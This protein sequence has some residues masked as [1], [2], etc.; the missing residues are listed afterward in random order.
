V[1]KGVGTDRGTFFIRPYEEKDERGVLSLWEA[2]FGKSMSP[3]LFK[4]K[5][6]DN[7][8]GHQMMLCV[9]EDGTPVAMYSGIPFRANWQGETVRF[10]HL[11]DHSSHPA[12]RSALG[13][14]RGLFVRT[15]AEFFDRYGGPHGSVFMYG[16]P[17][18][19]HFF[20]GEKLLQYVPLRGGMTFMSARPSDVAFQMRSFKGR[21]E[22]FDSVSGAFDVLSEACRSAYPFSV[23]RDAAFLN[24]RFLK[25]P[26]RRYEIWGYRPFL[27]RTLKAYA[28]LFHEPESSCIVDLFSL[29][30]DVRLADFIARLVNAMA[31]N[32]AQELKTWLPPDHFL[33][34]GLVSG[35]FRTGPEPIGF[36]PGGRTFHDKLGM[37]Q[38]SDQIFYTMADGDLC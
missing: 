19:R 34:K 24:W 23:L 15:A 20:L 3:A 25:H 37:D 36:I 22:A 32:G 9:G 1:E 27:G 29:D 35:G 28:V 13:G 2:A 31:E 7:P 18:K 4:W 12:Y 8:Y 5:W 10:T 16:F 14:R 26:E 30:A 6:L 33:T 21:I 17:G 11:M 38:V